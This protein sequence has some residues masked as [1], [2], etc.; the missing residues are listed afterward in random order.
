MIWRGRRL[1]GIGKTHNVLNMIGII[2]R[3]MKE[4]QMIKKQNILFS[5]GMMM[6]LEPWLFN[7]RKEKYIHTIDSITR[8]MRK[9]FKRHTFLY[10]KR[11]L[12]FTWYDYFLMNALGMK[13]FLLPEIFMD[14]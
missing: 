7:Y 10:L 2:A 8:L 5:L 13:T 11:G 9:R 12:F 1:N 3:N 14:S 6:G 4:M